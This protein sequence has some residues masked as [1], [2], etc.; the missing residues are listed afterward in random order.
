MPV[1]Y[2]SDAFLMRVLDRA[3]LQDVVS[4]M[5]P[6]GRLA[7]RLADTPCLASSTVAVTVC[8]Y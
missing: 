4:D 5:Q 6:N 2:Q 3:L 1:T 8:C 7:K